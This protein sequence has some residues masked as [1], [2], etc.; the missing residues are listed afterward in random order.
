MLSVLKDYVNQLLRPLVI[1]FERVGVKPNYL[2]FLGL[3]FGLVSFFFIVKSKLFFG[4][5]FLLLSGFMDTLDGC[6]ART[7][8]QV[9]NFGGF[10]DSVLDRYVDIIVLLGIGLYGVNWVIVLLAVTGSLLV[11]YTR[12]RAEKI[13]PRCDVGLAERAERILI[14]SAGLIFSKYLWYAVLAVAMLAHITAIHRVLHT[15]YYLKRNKQ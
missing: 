7:S 2:S 4:A 6:L 13:I 14:L 15:Y 11:S 10:L 8:N 12:A 3:F 9:S 1:C 5:I